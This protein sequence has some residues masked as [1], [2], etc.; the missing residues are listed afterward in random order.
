MALAISSAVELT[1]GVEPLGLEDFL[2][3]DTGGEEEEA[4][5]SLT[6]LSRGRDWE[7]IAKSLIEVEGASS[8]GNFCGSKGQHEILDS[9][10]SKVN[11]VQRSR[12]H[13]YEKMAASVLSTSFLPDKVIR[14]WNS[15]GKEEG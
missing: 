3:M 10:S 7:F 15:K 1:C 4:I 13:V 9:L 2:G 6:R 11:S 12:L 5:P 14:G 8:Y